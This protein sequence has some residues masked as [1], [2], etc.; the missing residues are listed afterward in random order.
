MS[1]VF[2]PLV[3][4][5]FDKKFPNSPCHVKNLV[6]KKEKRAVTDRSHKNTFIIIA[7]C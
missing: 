2:N 1:K 4:D 5:W 7:N 6:K 3:G